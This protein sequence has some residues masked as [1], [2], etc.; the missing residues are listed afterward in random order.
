MFTWGAPP[1]DAEGDLTL[2]ITG[3]KISA[4]IASKTPLVR[5]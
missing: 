1:N 5:F 3:I 4:K 2:F